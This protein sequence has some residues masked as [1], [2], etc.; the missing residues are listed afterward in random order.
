M[1]LEQNAK[2]L[3]FPLR[4]LTGL[5]IKIE[6]FTKVPLCD[7]LYVSWESDYIDGRSIYPQ[8]VNNFGVAPVFEYRWIGGNVRSVID[9]KVFANK[10]TLISFKLNRYGNKREVL[11]T[12]FCARDVNNTFSFKY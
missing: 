6:R 12:V 9:T 3:S 2:Y 4:K 8:R 10:R 5:S 1:Q 11:D 7:T